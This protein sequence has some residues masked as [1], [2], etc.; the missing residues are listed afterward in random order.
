MRALL[1]AAL[2]LVSVPPC[3]AE[4]D[5][6]LKLSGQNGA[7]LLPLGLGD[8]SAANAADASEAL[9]AKRIQDVVRDDLLFS[10][11]FRLVSGPDWKASGA[12]CLLS[13]RVQKS[14]DLV[15]VSARLVDLDS[16]DAVLERYYREGSRWTRA[17]AH[18]ISDDVVRQLTGKEGIAHTR[19]AFSNNQTG[20]KE[21]YVMDYDGAEIHQ[22]TRHHS[23]SIL[24]RF[25]PDGKSIAYTSYKDG[26]PDLFLLDLQRGES[27]AVSR[28]QGLNIAGGFSPDGT[29]LL[30]TLSREKSP[31]IYLKNLSD[32]SVLRLTHY[33][34]AD[35]SPTFSP[36]SRQVA[37]VSD[38]SGNPQIY[39][40]DL[41]TR[42]AR[43][44][45]DLNWCDSPSW[46]PTGE[47][48]A[49]SGRAGREDKL[50]I[51]VVDVTGS[52]VVRLTHDM[53]SNE[54]P[55]WSPDGRFLAFSSTR[56]GR[57]QLYVMDADGSAPHRIA[58]VPGDSVQPSW[59]N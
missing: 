9:L 22:L 42:R 51:Y 13:A 12:H 21:I 55:S 34:G 46:S 17:L 10:R 43:R 23:I 7:A 37:F 6:Y 3:R 1:A 35:S 48:I 29:E 28:D 44:L 30:M 11:R 16:G 40:L 36:D 50:E 59:S 27:R 33:F 32:R 15:A 4:T 41:T 56:D 38:R 52:Q 31:N 18:R 47:W 57:H 19:I 58:D 20:H 24:P 2:L 39:L 26:N 5:V 53:G 25:S 45:T 8:F 54:N 49:F 14:A